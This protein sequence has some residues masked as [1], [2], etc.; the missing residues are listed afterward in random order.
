[1]RFA[2]TLRAFLLAVIVPATCLA[3]D[4][5]LWDV[6]REP[7][8]ATDIRALRD[9]ESAFLQ[10]RLEGGPRADLLVREA[11][12]ALERVDASSSPD[13]RVRFFYGRLLSRTG[14]DARAVDVLRDAIAFAP[15]HPSVAEAMFARAVSLARLGRTG[16]EVAMYEAWLALEPSAEHRSIGLSNQAEGY[17]LVGRME[18]AVYTYGRAI[19]LVHDNALA[20]W[21]LAVA[22]D[23]FGDHPGA[24]REATTAL[25]YDPGAK[26]L[27]GP[28][29]FFVPEYDRFW[30]RALGAMARASSTDD[31]QLSALWWD[32]ATLLWQQFLDAAAVDNRWLPIARLRHAYC[33]Q[34]TKAAKA[35]AGVN[36]RGRR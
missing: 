17:M 6:A 19:Q 23:R 18:E 16:E 1:M 35:R 8:L 10:A 11:V 3:G 13:P 30:Y 34:A 12:L 26:E 31:P 14:Q 33:E 22:L 29:V 28:N 20:H 5:P 7:R 9:A 32:R 24:I 36:R 2:S 4:P 15:R 27:N 21:G 25:T